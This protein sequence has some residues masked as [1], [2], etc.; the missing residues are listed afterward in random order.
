MKCVA[1]ITFVSVAFVSHGLAVLRP[2]F[3]A[4]AGPPFNNETIITGNGSIQHPAKRPSGAA[5]KQRRQQRQTRRRREPSDID[6][7]QKGELTGVSESIEPAR[8]MRTC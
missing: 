2:I 7:A 3:P 5:Q 1:A 8:G 6:E 4:K